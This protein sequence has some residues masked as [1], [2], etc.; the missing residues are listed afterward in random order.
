M[1]DI[2]SDIGRALDPSSRVLGWGGANP[3]TQYTGAPTSSPALGQGWNGV[4]CKD[5]YSTA[6]GTG[7]GGV[8]TLWAYF[9][10]ANASQPL[11]GTVPVQLRE[12]LL[13][14]CPLQQLLL[15]SQRHPR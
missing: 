12:L 5:T 10:S 7:E 15:L 2:L 13:L 6:A 4:V 11:A 9:W 8:L 3:C 14:R 1:G